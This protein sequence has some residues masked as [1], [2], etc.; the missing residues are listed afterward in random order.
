MAKNIGFTNY[1]LILS[2]LFELRYLGLVVTIIGG[3]V[4]MIINWILLVS[5]STILFG[6]TFYPVY[7]LK[8]WIIDIIAIYC[9]SIIS[10][11]IGL[12]TENLN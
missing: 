12:K 8:I 5:D 11:T 4:G 6:Y 10:A 2:L 1:Q 7:E 9:L 3:I